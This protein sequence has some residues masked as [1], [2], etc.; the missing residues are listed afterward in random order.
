MKKIKE[1]FKKKRKQEKNSRRTSSTDVCSQALSC[2]LFA[3]A[4]LPHPQGHPMG[5]SENGHGAITTRCPCILDKHLFN[6]FWYSCTLRDPCGGT[7]DSWRLVFLPICTDGMGPWLW[8]QQGSHRAELPRGLQQKHSVHS[9][10]T[11]S[12]TQ[13]HFFW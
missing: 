12:I 9:T 2:R 8:P 4:S 7:T 6:W 3:T 10:P 11:P 1:L 13:K 5:E